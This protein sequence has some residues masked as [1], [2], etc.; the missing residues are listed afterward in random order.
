MP[1]LKKL[2]AGAFYAVA[3]GSEPQDAAIVHLT[4]S[5]KGCQ[6]NY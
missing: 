3:Q 5:P 2:G 4:Y 6:R 1:K